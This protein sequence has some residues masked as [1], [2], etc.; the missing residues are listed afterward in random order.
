MPP[1]AMA[2]SP[3]RPFPDAAPLPDAMVGDCGRI[4]CDC[5]FNGIPLFGRVQY[6]ESF[7]QITVRVTPFPD[8]RVREGSFADTC[9]EWEIVD[10]FPNFTVQIVTSFEDFGIEY[11]SFPGIP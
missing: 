1:R 9:G 2:P 4:Q 6:V 11:S 7:P 10:S 5:T 3:T 8:L